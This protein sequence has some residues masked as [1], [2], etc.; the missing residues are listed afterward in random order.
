MSNNNGIKIKII[1]LYNLF[2]DI[3]TEGLANIVKYCLL[4]GNLEK[5]IIV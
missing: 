1:N 5:I 4:E 2:H 3:N